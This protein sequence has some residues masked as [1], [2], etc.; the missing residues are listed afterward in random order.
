MSVPKPTPNNLTIVR[1][2]PQNVDF[3]KTGTYILG[4]LPYDNNVFVPTNAFIVYSNVVGP[5]SGSTQFSTGASVNI[6]DSISNQ[7]IVAATTLP[8]TGI[9][10]TSPANTAVTSGGTTL[11]GNLSQTILTL[12]GASSPGYIFG[13]LPLAD[14]LPYGANPISPT[15]SFPVASANAGGAASVQT[16]NFN[17]TTAAVPSVTVSSS[18]TSNNITTLTLSALPASFVPGAV[19]NVLG[20]GAGYNGTVTI[21]STT[22]SPNTITYYN[23]SIPSG[24]TGAGGTVGALSGNVYVTGY[25]F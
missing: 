8:V 19:V 14:Q 24:T 20:V 12:I 21:L 9:P 4:D 10:V 3:T 15:G 17:V 1:F 18:T 16:L 23:P 2:G 5:A 13:G 22:A 6:N 7:N 11:G 25:L